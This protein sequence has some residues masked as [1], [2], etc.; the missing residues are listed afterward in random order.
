MGVG[1]VICLLSFYI[2]MLSV[3]LL[4]EKNNTKLE[5]LLLLGYSPWRVSLPYQTITVGLNALVFVLALILLYIVRGLYMEMFVT[6][7]PSIEQP[8]M[9]CT[10]VVGLLIFLFVSCLNV[11]AIRNKILSIWKGNR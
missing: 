5:N 9:L 1:A 4:V 2:L 3:Y 7:F 10:I 11:L 6:L 8:S